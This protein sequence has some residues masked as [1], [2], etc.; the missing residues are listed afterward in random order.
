MMDALGRLLVPRRASDGRGLAE[1]ADAIA[2]PQL[3]DHWALDS[4]RAERQLVRADGGDVQDARVDALDGPSVL[5]V[6]GSLG[7][8][9]W[10][11][12]EE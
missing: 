12:D 11:H 6:Y 1:A 2:Q 9:W 5:V 7:S 4:D 8:I 3:H 10:E